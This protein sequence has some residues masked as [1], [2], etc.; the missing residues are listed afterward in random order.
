M[1]YL[2]LARHLPVLSSVAFGS[3]FSSESYSYWPRTLNHPVPPS[4]PHSP[5]EDV[6]TDYNG[7]GDGRQCDSALTSSPLSVPL[8]ELVDKISIGFGESVIQLLALRGGE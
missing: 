4:S 2:P 5:E 1:N 7:P 6:G 3:S 8:G